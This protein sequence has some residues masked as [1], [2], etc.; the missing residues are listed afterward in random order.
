MLAK[1][2]VFVEANCIRPRFAVDQILINLQSNAFLKAL[3]LCKCNK[4]QKCFKKG[5]TFLLLRYSMNAIKLL[6]LLRQR[7]RAT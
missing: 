4:K 2:Q 7:C 5:L 1:L 6:L 3:I